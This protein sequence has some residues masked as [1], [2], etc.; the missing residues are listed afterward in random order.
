MYGP[1]SGLEELLHMAVT[2]AAFRRAFLAR[3]IELAEEHDIALSTTEEAMLRS[4]SAEQLEQL[5]A[6][7]PAD[8]VAQYHDNV[9]VTGIRP[10]LPEDP[11]QP[12]PRDREHPSGDF[13]IVLRAD[14]EVKL[15]VARAALE[16]L[17]TRCQ[18]LAVGV[19]IVDAASKAV[20]TTEDFELAEEA[21]A[22]ILCYRSDP[23]RIADRA[24]QMHV[25]IYEYEHL[26]ELLTAVEERLRWDAKRSK[27][28]AARNV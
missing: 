10:D 28:R 25:T 16:R 19:L 18:D 6:N 26:S 24:Q 3:P 23:S 8:F 17:S 11:S 20:L 27:L 21:P 2:D 9:P 4:V 13:A 7:L 14:S 15:R 5:I 1:G 12:Q 22:D